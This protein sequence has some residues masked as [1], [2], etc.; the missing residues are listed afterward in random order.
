MSKRDPLSLLYHESHHGRCVVV[1]A[2]EIR[3]HGLMSVLVVTVYF[4]AARAPWP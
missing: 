1:R 4:K 3:L 2:P